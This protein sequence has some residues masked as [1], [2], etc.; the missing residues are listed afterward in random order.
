MVPESQP[1][2][3]TRG[4]VGQRQAPT[5]TTAGKVHRMHRLATVTAALSLSLTAG[6]S[7]PDSPAPPA[8][9]A[10][11]SPEPTVAT[12][13][14][15]R[16]S[17]TK[18][19]VRRLVTA[20]LLAALRP[21]AIRAHLRALQA[22]ADGADG[23]RATGTRGYLGSMRHV[24]D[25]LIAAGYTPVLEPFTRG[26]ISGTNVLA[27]RTGANDDRVVIIG[28]HLDSVPVGPGINDN[29]SGVAVLLALADALAEVPAPEHTIR[30]AFWDAE[31]GGPIGSAA[32]VDAL[33]E[34]ERDRIVAYLNL[35]MVASPNPVRFVYDETA[36]APG[37]SALTDAFAA[38]F[39]AEGLAWDP[40]DLGGDSDHGPFAAAGIPTGGVFTGGIEDVTPEQ[41]ARHGATAG[42]PSDACSHRACDTLENVD[43]EL[44]AG[45]A[46]IVAVVLVQLAAP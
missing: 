4:A 7:A 14:V 15:S 43:A 25:A 40:I 45:M 44:A 32:H 23:T 2:G 3:K 35:D 24:T 38:A 27:E 16:P 28:A 9:T 22:I 18:S 19:A 13:P 31:E 12:T 20:D 11:P 39:D 8:R 21:D 30:L 29:G 46:R 5:A 1:D 6:C 34:A 33:P 36:A 26:G 41:A 10:M 42:V 37:S 17:P